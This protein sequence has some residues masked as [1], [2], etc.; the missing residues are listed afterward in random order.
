MGARA[1]KISPA[2]VIGRFRRGRRSTAP[3]SNEST[4]TGDF[5]TQ[6]QNYHDAADSGLAD[7]PTPPE[8]EVVFFNDRNEMR[9]NPSGGG[10]DSRR[11][12]RIV[13]NSTRNG[14]ID[15]DCSVLFYMYA[16]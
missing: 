3:T 7:E 12:W 1:S 15:G 13:K 10:W 8:Q 9:K 11:G 6:I 16:F 2:R 14:A 5:F 4:P